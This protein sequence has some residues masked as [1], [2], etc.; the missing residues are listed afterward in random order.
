MSISVVFTIVGGRLI[1][2]AFPYTFVIFMSK[3]PGSDAEIGVFG[4]G[5]LM[6]TLNFA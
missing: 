2:T 3:C 1:T 5:S 4:M 6:I